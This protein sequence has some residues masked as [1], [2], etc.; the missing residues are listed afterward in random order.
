MPL[1]A[2]G[3][4]S[5]TAS[6]DGRVAYVAH[7][8]GITRIDVSSRRARPLDAAKDITLAEFEFIRWHRDV[9]IGSQVQPDG[10]RG[11]VRLRLN[12]DHSAVS[13]ATLIDDPAS[14]EGSATF[15]TIS[16]DDLYYVVAEGPGSQTVGSPL[17]DVRVMRVKLR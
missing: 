9:L 15:A 7:R 6:D 11:L 8:E 1:T 17:I 16:G 5:I 13:Q 3:P 2:P 12:R 4:V 10:S 14:S